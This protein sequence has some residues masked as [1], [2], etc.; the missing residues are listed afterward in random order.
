[1]P[2]LRV[3]ELLNQTLKVH[4]MQQILFKTNNEQQACL[5]SGISQKESV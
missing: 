2:L 3:D 1:M 5:I 4:D